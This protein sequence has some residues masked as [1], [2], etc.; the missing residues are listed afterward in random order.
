MSAYHL[1]SNT[2]LLQ[3]AITVKLLK[4][5]STH[6]EECDFEGFSGIQ[7][8]ENGIHLY[9]SPQANS[10]M[11]TRMIDYLVATATLAFVTGMSPFAFLPMVWGFLSMPRK[12]QQTTHFTYHAEL[13]PHTE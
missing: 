3:N 4:A 6:K 10:Y 13:H 1:W 5:M 8:H 2:P 9:K 7:T 11:Q 12:M